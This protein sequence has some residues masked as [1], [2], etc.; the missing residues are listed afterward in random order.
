MA[1]VTHWE[2]HGNP[3]Q[4]LLLSVTVILL[5]IAVLYFVNNLLKIEEEIGDAAKLSDFLDARKKR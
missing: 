2:W 5:P 1:R 4:L 3:L